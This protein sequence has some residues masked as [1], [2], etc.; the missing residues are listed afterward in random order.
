MAVKTYAASVIGASH[1][2][3]PN[4]ICEDSS[5]YDKDGEISGAIVL[6]V[7]DGHG[8]DQ[9]KYSSD[10]SK[11]AVKVFH[12]IIKQL[13]EDERLN[14][15]LKGFKNTPFKD[16]EL[17]KQISQ[18]W[19]NRI[20]HVHRNN[21][22]REQEFDKPSKLSPLDMVYKKAEKHTDW[23]WDVDPMLYGTTL[24]G[25]AIMGDDILVYQ[26]GDGDIVIVDD[27]G[28]RN[29]IDGDHFLGVETYSL[30]HKNSW[31]YAKTDVVTV[32]DLHKK[33]C[34]IMLSSDGLANSYASEEEFHN[35]CKDY[36]QVIRDNGFD[37]VCKAIGNDKEGWL[38]ETSDGGCGDDISL[39]LA[40]FTPED[41]DK[42]A[43]TCDNKHEDA[44]TIEG[45]D[46]EAVLVQKNNK[47][48]RT[49]F[50]ELE[51]TEVESK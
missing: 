16:V 37:A 40:Y 42:D 29:L 48:E 45:E 21:K 17:T 19:I 36:Y 50:K 5:W 26:I 31:N 49:E 46:P 4:P 14:G 18:K 51:F 44:K 39:A 6:A 27:D 34:L 38:R 25:I 43:T 32:K 24:L 2:R 20:T 11:E 9:C 3:K 13:V 30:A 22:E 1:L 15:N 35:A 10:G 8:S 7:A 12:T 47:E 28:V 33:P 23:Y 41:E